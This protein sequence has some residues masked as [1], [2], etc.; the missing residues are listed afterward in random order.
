MYNGSNPCYKI[1][2]LNV[3]KLSNFSYDTYGFKVIVCLFINKLK[4]NY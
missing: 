3:L 1:Y 2:D 4:Y